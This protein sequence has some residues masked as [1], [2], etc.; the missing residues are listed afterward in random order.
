M[1]NS[2][3]PHGLKCT[4]HF[5]PL[6]YV[7]EYY[8]VTKRRKGR[9]PCH[10]QPHIWVYLCQ[11]IYTHIWGCRYLPKDMVISFP[12]DIYSKLELLDLFLIFWCDF[13]L[14]SLVTASIY[15][16]TNSAQGLGS[17]NF[18]SWCT[19]QVC[20]RMFSSVVCFYPKDVSGTLSPGVTRMSPDIAECPVEVKITL[21]WETVVVSVQS[22]TSDSLWPH[23]L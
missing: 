7:V 20:S 2:L 21:G 9:K 17:G 5:C 19:V 18:W 10:L 22:V 3:W 8:L 13:I 11:K 4:R 6:L 23:G 12:L 14:F 15:I 16:P 1:S